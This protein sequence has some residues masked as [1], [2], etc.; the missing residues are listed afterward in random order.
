MISYL[1]HAIEPRRTCTCEYVRLSFVPRDKQ[2]D[3]IVRQAEI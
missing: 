3:D 2:E 1:A